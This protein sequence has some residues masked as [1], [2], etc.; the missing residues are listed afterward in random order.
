MGA[1]PGNNFNP[2]GRPQKPIDWE[3]FEKL[4]EMQC[5]QREIAGWFKVDHE[6][7]RRRS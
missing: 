5:T 2:K 6:T 3:E 1:P 4:C 7:I